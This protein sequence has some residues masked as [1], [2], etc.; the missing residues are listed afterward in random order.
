MTS[1]TNSP[2]RVRTPRK[3]TLLITGLALIILIP[4]GVGFTKKLFEFFH[5]YSKAEDGAFTLIPIANYLLVTAGFCCLLGW[6]IVHGMFRDVERPKYTML[7]T[8]A[9]LD[10]AEGHPWSNDA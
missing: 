8:E 1:E 3:K 4:A 7:E 10:R 5:T 2:P 6:A 9:K